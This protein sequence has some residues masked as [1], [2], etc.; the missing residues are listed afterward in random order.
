MALPAYVTAHKA[1]STRAYFWLVKIDCS[2]PQYL[3]TADLPIEYAG[4]TY[5]PS[6]GIEIDGVGFSSE[7]EIVSARIRVANNDAAFGVLVSGFVGTSRAP[8]VTIYEAWFPVPLVDLTPAGDA[9][10][11]LTMGRVG[12]CS[13]DSEWVDMTIVPSINFAAGK[14]P[15]RAYDTACGY[16]TFAYPQCGYG[17]SPSAGCNRS[18][19]RCVALANTS[20]FGGF[21]FLPNEDR[22]WNAGPQGSVTIKLTRR[23]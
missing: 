1:D 10:Y 2:P 16:R 22:E 4:A 19:D 8:A 13:W 17:G 6:R 5:T 11:V 23:K 3:T 9:V 21:R 7:G 18:W 14:V 15:W 20:R 12:Q